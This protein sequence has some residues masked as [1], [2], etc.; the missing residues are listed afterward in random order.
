MKATR[1]LPVL[2]LVLCVPGIVLRAMHLVYGFDIDTGLPA[3]NGGWFWGCVSLFVLC[4]VLYAVLSLPLRKR[5]EEPFEALLGTRGA[6]FRMA[7]VISGLLLAV[8]GA[9]Y[10]YVVLTV[11]EPNAAGWAHIVEYIYAALTVLLGAGV[12]ALAQAQGGEMTA[13][14]AKLTLLPLLWSCVHLLV[15]YRMT[16]ID[17]KLPA[18]A[19]GLIADVLMTLAFY[20]LARLLYSKPRPASLA[21]CCAIAVTMA[22]SDLGGYGLALVMGTRAVDWSARLLLRSG[23]SAAACVALLAELM[24]LTYPGMQRVHEDVQSGQ[25]QA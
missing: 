25:A 7:M 4:A 6:G 19:F 12:I 8:G 3:L 21:F 22:F 2:A 9:W 13:S 5:K 10:F 15:T 11:P 16:C 17:P 23:L 20:Q 18:F 1:F 14:R 24:V